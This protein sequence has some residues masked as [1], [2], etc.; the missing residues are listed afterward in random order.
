MVLQHCGFL[1]FCFCTGFLYS[2]VVL[3]FHNCKE[4]M[5]GYGSVVLQYC[6]FVVSFF[7]A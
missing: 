7:C 5:G 2:S 6:G 4:L 1:V 3:Q